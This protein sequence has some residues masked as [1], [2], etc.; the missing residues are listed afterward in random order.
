M[1]INELRTKSSR[2]IH[3][4]CSGQIGQIVPLFAI[5]VASFFA[6]TL[7]ITRAFQLSRD[8][9]FEREK[10]VHR[11]MR[12]RFNSAN[13]LNQ[14]ANNNRKIHQELTKILKKYQSTVLAGDSIAGSPL[15]WEHALPIPLPYGVTL[16]LDAAV[17]S[18]VPTLHALA[19]NNRTT[20]SALAPELQAQ[21]KVAKMS[22]SICSLKCMQPWSTLISSQ[23]CF[24]DL[25]ESKSCH[26]NLQGRS[27][28]NSRHSSMPITLVLADDLLELD[29]FMHFNLLNIKNQT[30]KN[31][32]TS[33]P[34]SESLFEVM[35]VHPR[36]CVF[37]EL[38]NSL[39]CSGK[40]LKSTMHN[41]F[42]NSIDF[43]PHW[44][45]AVEYN[46]QI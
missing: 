2:S 27:A 4:G 28:L 5:L 13:A 17:G 25:F 24:G 9:F 20:M 35:L 11:L 18:V 8:D 16:P 21:M 12:E 32:I 46:D 29:G 39:P 30:K 15:L 23:Q 45:V 1:Q 14:I 7:F 19:H 33:Q 26:L 44:S 40:I 3:H 37:P 38:K 36:F 41:E 10:S 31:T 34:V 22:A 43:E 42:P 6:I